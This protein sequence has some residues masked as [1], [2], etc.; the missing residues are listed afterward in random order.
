[1][2]DRGPDTTTKVRH[3]R[4]RV[5]IGVGVAALVLALVA[6]GAIWAGNR[7]ASS[8]PQASIRLATVERTSLV[9]GFVLSGTLGYGDA[10]PLG[11]GGGIV[12]KV[13]EAGQMVGAGQ[14]VMEVEGAPV[15]LLQGTLPLWREIGPGVSGPD[16]GMVR[17][18][19]AGLGFGS[20]DSQT[21]DQD[22]SNAIGAMYAAAGYQTVP[23]SADQLQARTAAAQT[24]SD[25]QAALSDAQTSLSTAKNRK[26]SQT[27]IVSAKN[28]LTD[29]YR[30]LNAVTAGQCPDPTHTP[31]T[32]AEIA[33]AQEAVDLAQAQWDDVNAAP[34]TSAEQAQVTA[35]QRQ[36]NDAQ[37]AVNQLGMNTVG[38]RSVL[39]VPQA[40]IR[41]DNVAA[42]VG[43]PAE[44]TVLTWT[45]TTLYGRANL[46]DAQK[47][48]LT[49]GTAAIMTAND[50]TQVDGTVGEITASST[51]PQTG[52]TTPAGV[53]IDISDQTT[54]AR[55]GPGA[56]KISFIQDEVEDTLVVPVTALMALAEGGYC[57][58]RPDGT[59]VPVRIGLVADTKAQVFSD[60]LH[61][62]DQVVIP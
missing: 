13:P 9:S 25:A 1:M 8:K 59:L 3:P 28:G 35:A 19:L 26:P 47:A 14:V 22:L 41:I 6:V 4:R 29:A 32:A 38:P 48:M 30:N 7:S 62:G 57:V 40:Q 11:G 44:G 17:S 34:D 55:L 18:A 31:C 27:E 37:S 60:D 50:G 12:T 21:Y 20:G 10:T 42:K 2:K 46:T 15:F 36:V 61:Q 53:R 5:L 23:P 49:T 39:V 51:D 54:V 56:V 52:Q 43:L 33:D 58:E 24:L 16:V 45:E